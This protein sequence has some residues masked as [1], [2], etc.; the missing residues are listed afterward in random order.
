MIAHLQV[1][2]L[3]GSW[4]Q[5][6]SPASLPQLNPQLPQAQQTGGSFPGPDCEP[7]PKA[8]P[9]FS[10]ACQHVQLLGPIVAASAAAA[11]APRAPVSAMSNALYV[12]RIP[13]GALS[14]LVD[15]GK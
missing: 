9:P 2:C 14:I 1:V 7:G 5:F 10:P 6:V 13:V 4:S 8:G 12:T 15:R 3:D 11:A